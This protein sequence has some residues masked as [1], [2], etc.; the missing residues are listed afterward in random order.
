M[1]VVRDVVESV[2]AETGFTGVVRVDR[3]GE[4]EFAGAYGLADRRHGIANR[5]DT[6]FAIASGTKG[7]TALTVVS[8]IEQGLLG[9][10]TRARAVLGDDLP[11]IGAEVTVEHLLAHRSGIGDYTDEDA[12]HAITDHVLPVSVH[13]LDSAEGYLAV[14]D[15]HP[16]KFP[17]GERF[18]YRNAGQCS[19]LQ[20]GGVG[21]RWEGRQGSTSALNRSC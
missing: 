15:G 21:P 4:V 1:S 6:R 8:L 11:L 14:L 18:G 2:V 13:R 17:A 9:L 10:D 20:D 7:L 3:A 12:G 5:L 16:A 19:A